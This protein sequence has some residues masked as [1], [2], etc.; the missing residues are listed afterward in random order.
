MMRTMQAHLF[1]YVPRTAILLVL[2]VFATAL[3]AC[4]GGGDGDNAVGDVLH[5]N[6][7][8]ISARAMQLE[9]RAQLTS[10]PLG[11]SACRYYDDMTVTEVVESIK[12]ANPTPGPR[13]TPA[14]TSTPPKSAVMKDGQ[15]EDKA[16]LEKGA[17]II[18]SECKR[19][20]G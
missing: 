12:R 11:A 7:Y 5:F 14:P 20:K 19:L 1:Q 6:G 3:A 10:S 4:G 16:S 2:V 13:T 18:L 15:V 8:D 17:A 9:V